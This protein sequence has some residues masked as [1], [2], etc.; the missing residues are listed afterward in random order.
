MLSSWATTHRE[1]FMLSWVLGAVLIAIYVF[2]YDRYVDH[3]SRWLGAFAFIFLIAGLGGLLMSALQF[4]GSPSADRHVTRIILLGIAITVGPML[5]GFDGVAL[6]ALNL[7]AAILLAAA[8]WAYWQARQEAPGPI[9]GLTSLYMVAALSFVMCAVMIGLEGSLVLGVA[10]QNWAETLNVFV[11]MIA[12]A[13]IG[14]LSLALNHAR[15]SQRHSRN[16]QTDPLTGLMNRRAL[17]D[18]YGDRPLGPYVTVAAFDLDSFKAVNDTYGHAAGD[19]VLIGFAQIM[20]SSKRPGDFAVRLGGEEFALVM[21]RTLPDQAEAVA[22]SIRMQ[23][24][25]AAI[26]TERGELTCTVSVG[27]AAGDELGSTFSQ[28]LRSADAALYQAKS[29]GR[30]RLVRSNLRLVPAKPGLISR[31]NRS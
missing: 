4:S 16:A 5:L 11:A 2:L 28:V 7:A 6:F 10:P 14:A 1:R 8:G 23:F 12:I 21:P 18:L 26:D 30:D 3:P 25:M 20:R 22:E 31:S 13:S 27:L 17:F 9:A 19:D 24:A 29:Q 15:N